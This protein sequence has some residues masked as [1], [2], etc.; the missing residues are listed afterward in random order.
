MGAPRGR[1]GP[2]EGV[3]AG[4]AVAGGSHRSEGCASSRAPK[5]G[6]RRRRSAACSASK[7]AA[8][9]RPRAGARGEPGRGWAV[10]NA[11]AAAHEAGGAGARRGVLGGQGRA[12]RGM[13]RGVGG[14]GG[15]RGPARSGARRTAAGGAG[16]TP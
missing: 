8:V 9:P 14:A 6:G 15:G 11:R 3:L 4:A 5:G 7:R 13:V 1:W 16:L 12:A 2:G 10:S